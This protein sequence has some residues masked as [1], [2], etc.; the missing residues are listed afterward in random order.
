MLFAIELRI[1]LFSTLRSESLAIA[2]LASAIYDAL[3][4]SLPEDSE[5]TISRSLEQLIERM[6]SGE[7]EEE[8]GEDE[9]VDGL[10][11]IRQSG[12]CGEILELCR[13]HLASNSEAEGHYRAVCRALVAEALEISLFMEKLGKH[14]KQ[15]EELEELELGDWA[16]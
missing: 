7:E 4:Y 11:V 3:D 13:H 15:S 9:G 8:D 16:R 12:Q 6:T 1:I 10:Y 14:G 5:R 2:D